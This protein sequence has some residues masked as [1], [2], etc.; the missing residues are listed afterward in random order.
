MVLIH[1]NSF[2]KV[3]VVKTEQT[4]AAEAAKPRS[5]TARDNQ[6][7][8]VNKS[9]LNEKIKRK[10]FEMEVLKNELK[11]KNKLLNDLNNRMSVIE[12]DI[13]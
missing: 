10:D 11:S 7:K 5:S 4:Q 1:L 3:E 6:S 13:K 12:N 9:S 2:E 8:Q